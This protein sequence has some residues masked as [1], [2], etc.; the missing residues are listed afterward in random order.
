[1]DPLIP[2]LVAVLLASGIDR[3]PVLTAILADRFGP[4]RAFAGAGAAQAIGFTFSALA[5]AWIARTLTPEPR[6]LLVAV[7]LLSA[8]GS[9]LFT[10]RIKDRLER[11]RFGGIAVS[12]VGM[13]ILALGDR[14]QLLVFALAARNPSPWL[15]TIG[16]T[17]AALGVTGAAAALGERGWSK[18]PFRVMRPAIAAV[19]MITGTIVALGALRLI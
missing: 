5:G 8:G 13:A 16:A 11:W 3:P 9:S 7:A 12:F 14:S 4:V 19:L 2:T 1:M 17:V 10:P 15:A 18:L 6:S